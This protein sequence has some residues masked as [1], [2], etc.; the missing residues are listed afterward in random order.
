MDKLGKNILEGSL[1]VIKNFIVVKNK[2]ILKTTRNKYDLI[3]FKATEM[4]EYKDCEFPYC[5]ALDFGPRR[6]ATRDPRCDLFKKTN[7]SNLAADF[8]LKTNIL[9]KR[10][11][12]QR[13]TYKLKFMLWEKLY[14]T[15]YDRKM[16]S[17]YVAKG[18]TFA[19]KTM[20]ADNY[21]VHFGQITLLKNDSLPRNI[22]LGKLVN[23]LGKRFT[24]ETIWLVE[25]ESVEFTEE[26]SSLGKIYRGP[27]EEIF[28]RLEI[29]ENG[30]CNK[31]LSHSDYEMYGDLF[32]GR[33][34]VRKLAYLNELHDDGLY[35]VE[36]TIVD[37]LATKDC[38]YVACRKCERKR[39][40]NETTKKCIYCDEE[41]LFDVFRYNFKVMVVDESDSATFTMWNKPSV[42]LIGKCAG[43]IQETYGDSTGS[44]PNIIEYALI[45]K[46]ALFEVRITS[47]RSIIEGDH[48][49]V[50]RIAVDEEIIDIFKQ[51][52]I[53][54][55]ISTNDH[56]HVV[57]HAS[58]DAGNIEEE[59]RNIDAEN[60]G[61]EMIEA[62]SKGD[63]DV[64]Y[65]LKRKRIMGK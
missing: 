26:I 17:D 14:L 48:H 5:H 65:N 11:F 46:K 51:V 61:E 30:R 13:N 1:Y 49:N 36:A 52:Y 15:N 31:V 57:V 60:S 63:T 21:R 9:N 2:N 37:I 42:N 4:N 33:A 25:I 39:V 24:E 7:T 29:S 35:W 58:I 23:F 64:T 40:L 59:N 28:P 3:F 34:R 10:N 12:S 50:V 43:E 6:I 19:L 47:D 45:N 44:I 62:A 38:W 20:R 22:F 18:W 16:F 32:K 54:Q 8:I 55:A 27:T 53:N 41:N 56:H